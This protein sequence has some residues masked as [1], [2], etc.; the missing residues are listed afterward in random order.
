VNGLPS[1]R[2]DKAPPP[3]LVL[4]GDSCST[5]VVVRYEFRDPWMTLKLAQL[6]TRLM[7]PNRPGAH[8]SAIARSPIKMRVPTRTWKRCGFARPSQAPCISCMF[9]IMAS[10]AAFSSS[11]GLK[12]RT[13]L[14]ASWNGTWPGGA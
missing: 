12:E 7:L 1:P 10:S 5:A 11:A 9:F 13:S 4:L 14:L 3:F 2:R 8:V 6:A